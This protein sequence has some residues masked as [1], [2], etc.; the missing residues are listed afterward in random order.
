[1]SF[2]IEDD[3]LIKCD[4]RESIIQ[5]PYGIKKIGVDAFKGCIFIKEINMPDT[6]YEIQDNSFK[7]CKNLVKINISK[8]LKE[9]GNYVFHKCHSLEKIILPNSVDKLGNCVFLGCN[10]LKEVFLLGVKLLGKQVFLNNVNL[11]KIHISKDIDKSCIVDVFTGC[12]KLNKI[13]F[14]DNE[15]YEIKSFID[16]LDYKDSVPELVE[17]IIKDVY[18][19]MDFEQGVLKKFLVNL[20]EIEI[21]EGIK[22]IGKSCF[23]DKKGISRIKFPKSLNKINERAFRNCVSL[24]RIEFQNYDIEICD[25]SFKNCTSLK[26]INFV[27]GNEYELSGIEINNDYKKIPKLVK[28][29]YNQVIG[30]FI[31]SGNTLIR[32]IG[33]EERVT[34]P[35]GIEII[36]ERAFSKNETILKL[37]LPSSVKIIEEEAFSDCILLQRIILSDNI[38]YIGES[39]FENC[40]KLLKIE[41]PKDIHIINKSTFSRCN[42]LVNVV[43]NENL[44]IIDDFAFYKCK[45]IKNININQGIEYIGEL[46]FYM[47]DSIYNISIPKSVKFLGSNSFCHSGVRFVELYC[48]NIEKNAFAYCDKLKEIVFFD[49]VEEIGETFAISCTN[50]T[51]VKFCETIKYI[52]RNA[53]LNTP[54]LNNINEDENGIKIKDNI[55]FGVN[56]SVDNLIINDDIKI[57]AGGVFYNSNVTKVD[58]NKS[59]KYL[60]EYTFFDCK[61]L[62]EVILPKGIKEIPKSFFEGCNN[63]NIVLLNDDNDSIEFINERAFSYCEN[64]ENVFSLN[65]INKICYESFYYLYK[66]FKKDVIYN[67]IKF[68]YSSSHYAIKRIDTNSYNNIFI[69]GNCIINGYEYKDETLYIPE[70]ITSIGGYAFFQNNY[71]KKVIFPKSLRYIEEEAFFNCKNLEEIQFNSKLNFIGYKAFSNC[72]SLREMNLDVDYI[73]NKA[74]LNCILLKKLT[75]NNVLVIENCAFMNCNNINNLVLKNVKNIMKESFS[76]C[77]EIEEL[78]LEDIKSVG[79]YAFKS[80]KNLKSLILSENNIIDSRA[81]EDCSSLLNINILGSAEKL[82][83]R[84]YAFTGCTNLMNI[85]DNKNNYFISGI[86]FLKEN[87]PCY[88]KRIY[89]S[90]LTCFYIDENNKLIKYYN[91]SDKVNIPNGVVSINDEVFRNRTNLKYI[92]IPDTVKYIGSR[93]FHNTEWLINNRLKNPFVMVNNMLIDASLCKG[94]VNIPENIT[95]IC[96]WALA[97]GYT[98]ETLIFNINENYLKIDNYAFRNCINL[99]NIILKN[100]DEY[101]ISSIN[102]IELENLP[103]IIKKIINEAYNCF[104]VDRDNILYEST[105][106]ISNIKFPRGIN[107]IKEK[108]FID[109]YL[110]KEVIFNEDIKFIDK[111]CFMNCY[112]LKIVKCA[113]NIEYINEKA[114]SNCIELEY[115]E[116]LYNLKSLG[117]KAFENCESLKE[118]ILPEGLYEILD[119]TFFRC[120]NLKRV[121]IPSSI[122]FIGEKAFAFCE[123]LEEIIFLGDKNLVDIE[124]DAFYG[125]NIKF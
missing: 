116:N 36:G 106:S 93:A 123:S 6:I 91:Y 98:I 11:E 10:N 51:N 84:S 25:D 119:R 15:K 75:L 33:S 122:K 20:K 57:I 88:I 78:N 111:E 101:T 47:C 74:F 73:K 124:D 12:Y 103:N 109:C 16:I 56:T 113:D 105:K 26:Y 85:S 92:N 49:G 89:S 67:N 41:L 4:T 59:F 107:G 100:N 90:A 27:N 71:I 32:Y 108:V 104:K 61:N 114:F 97:G 50:L 18:R 68:L 60:N 8:N 29:I 64:L 39:A 44:K 86:K 17:L 53:F 125:C 112:Y 99:K 66:F 95:L 58:F 52:K 1:M 120:K 94:I 21:C 13:Y 5:I 69:F 40:L 115:I 62:K 7:G 34:V 63:L 2:V 46:A 118:I 48:K 3:I 14:S 110:L 77:Y 83:F 24:E 79:K 37:I 45:N 102:D 117:K 31:I 38:N 28:E 22:E 35:D 81:F 55:I 65:N 42:S 80:C 87:N 30:N 82:I 96:G 54:F 70:G 23:F 9:I 19:M 43:L 121:F 76:N 72:I